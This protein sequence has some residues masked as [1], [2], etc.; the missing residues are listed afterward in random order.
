LLELA[1]SLIVASNA[2]YKNRVGEFNIGVNLFCVE[3]HFR[4]MRQRGFNVL[5]AILSNLFMWCRGVI[6][7]TTLAGALALPIL[8]D[9]FQ[10]AFALTPPVLRTNSAPLKAPTVLTNAADVVLTSESSSEA[11]VQ[12]FEA[13]SGGPVLRAPPPHDE[14]G[15]A[16][17]FVKGKVLDPIT[18]LESVKV[19]K[20]QMTGGIVN[21]IERKNPLCLLHPLVFAVDW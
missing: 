13:L 10:P 11:A 16:Y 8:A 6:L 3:C 4:D 19:G 21:A 18:D 7:V 17:G 14:P 9:D 1:L 2:D 5:S 15:G 20:A 12:R